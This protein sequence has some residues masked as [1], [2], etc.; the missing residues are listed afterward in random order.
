MW[1]ALLGCGVGALQPGAPGVGNRMSVA[2][3]AELMA[4]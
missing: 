4:A 1:G 2:V 3:H